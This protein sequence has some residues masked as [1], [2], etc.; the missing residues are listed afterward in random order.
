MVRVCI[1]TIFTS[2][3]WVRIEHK[4]RS[5]TSTFPPLESDE[6]MINTQN[7]RGFTRY[8]IATKTVMKIHIF[9]TQGA[10]RRDSKKQLPMNNLKLVDN[11]LDMRIN[12]IMVI[13]MMEKV[14]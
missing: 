11:I 12:L 3:G 1:Q 10:F 14:G 4:T 8:G 13:M 9:N 6:L 7:N 2:V 5:E